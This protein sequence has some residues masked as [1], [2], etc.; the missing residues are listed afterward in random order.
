MWPLCTG[1]V[2]VA[3]ALTATLAL[4]HLEHPV[5]VVGPIALFTVG[6]GLVMPQ[7]MAG[8]LTPFPDRAGTASALLGFIQMSLGA[9]VGAAVG[10][11]DNG[12]AAPMGIIIG[13]TGAAS[14]SAYL[15]IARPAFR[16]APAHA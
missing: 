12:T 15:L 5:S 13:L 6:V 4:M 7:A 8:A 3:G 16:D 11:F 10:A 1:V 14:L 9:L 2:A